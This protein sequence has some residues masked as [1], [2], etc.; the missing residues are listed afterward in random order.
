MQWLLCPSPVGCWCRSSALW[1]VR[2]EHG[3]KCVVRDCESPYTNALWHLDYHHGSLR[4]LRA[5]GTWIYPLLLGILHDHSRL[6]CHCRWYEAVT[7]ENL[8]HGLMQAIVKRGLPRA[9]MSDNGSAML[10]A[11]TT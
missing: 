8:I 7:A 10:A 5:D 9:L 4:V 2:E 6:C 11:E 3:G 1:V